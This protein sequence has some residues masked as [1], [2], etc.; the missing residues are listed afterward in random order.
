ML[1]FHES[2]RSV[3]KHIPPRAD[4]GGIC[5]YYHR[6]LLFQITQYRKSRDMPHGQR[7]SKAAGVCARELE[8]A[9]T[10]HF[11]AGIKAF[12]HCILCAQHMA[13]FVNGDTA[14]GAVDF[15]DCL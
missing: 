7:G 8:V 9:G 15:R 1:I 2:V 6:E 5:L 11:A 12:D 4:L 10:G 13:G 3:N 14:V